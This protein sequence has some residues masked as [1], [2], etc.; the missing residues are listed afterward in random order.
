MRVDDRKASDKRRIFQ[1]CWEE[2]AHRV[3]EQYIFAR[4]YMYWNV[5]FHKTTRGYERLASTII[6]RVKDLVKQNSQPEFTHAAVS[7]L[8]ANTAPG[9]TDYLTLDDHVLLSQI[10]WWARHAKDNILKDLCDRFINRRGLKPVKVP[11]RHDQSPRDQKDRDKK[12]QEFLRQRDFVPEYYL[13]DDLTST[14]AYVPY[15]VERTD[16][17]QSAGNAILIH[18][19][20]KLVEISQL[21]EMSRLKAVTGQKEQQVFFYVPETC[22]HGVSRILNG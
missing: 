15:T 16:A 7:K 6:S 4:Y 18:K 14:V 2:K 12:A 17:E 20:D 3:I 19:N 11:G 10:N 21:P 22:R 9:L 5:Y 1:T 8:F 13:L